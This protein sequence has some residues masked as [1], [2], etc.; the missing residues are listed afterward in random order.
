MGKTF[1]APELGG[2]GARH[3]TTRKVSASARRKKQAHTSPDDVRI[4]VEDLRESDDFVSSED[5]PEDE[6]SEKIYISKRKKGAG[7]RFVGDS[8]S[9]SNRRPEEVDVWTVTGPVPGGPEDD[10]VIPSFLG[11]VASRLWDGAD[12]GVLKCQTRHGALKKLRQWYETASEEVKVLIDGTEISHLPFIMFDHLDIPLLSAFVERWQP[13]TNSFHM[14]FGEMTITLHD[15]W[16]ILRIPV[17]GAMVSGQPNKAQLMAYCVQ[18]LGISPEDLVSKTSKHFAQGGVLIESIISLC[19]HDRT[20]EVEAIAWI[21]LTLG[22][23][24]FTDKSGHRIRPA[25]IWEVREGVTDT[26][27]VSWGSATLAYLYRQLGISSRGDCSGLTGCL[28]LLQTWIYEYFPCFRPQ[29]ERLLIESH[30]PRAS[31]WSATASDCSAT[32]LRSLRAR[33]D[34]LTAEEITWLP[35]GGEPAATIEHTA[36]YGWIAY[37]DIVEPYMP[38][39]VLRQLGYVQTVPVPICRPIGAVRSWKS[40]KYSVD[41][42][43]T[44]AVDMWNAFPVMYKLPLM[45]FEEAHVIAGGCHPAYLDWFERHSHP[46]ILPDRDVPRRHP[47]RSNNDYW[48]TLVTSRY[49]HFIQKVSTITA[50]H[51]QHCEFDGIPE[52]ETETEEAS[53]ELERVIAAWRIAD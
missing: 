47:P 29:R 33:L 2:S 48:M 35:F 40:L 23:T 5:E 11:H 7:G 49:E 41:M 42:S 10:T 14:P 17:A 9:G 3:V 31:S 27:T 46:R 34:T 32:R 6:P 51:R 25:T 28:T 8:S 50:Q 44:I 13:D 21:W 18:I 19:R 39:R 4:P 12:R 1:L 30:L 36:Y 16:H 15:V 38:S 26:S 20:A 45:G 43:V 24:L 53:T 52:L 22:C 37:R